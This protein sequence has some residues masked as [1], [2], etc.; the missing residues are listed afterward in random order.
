MRHLARIHACCAQ[1]VM[2]LTAAHA[3]YE[4]FIMC[5]SNKPFADDVKLMQFM[6]V[7][8]FWAGC[9]QLKQ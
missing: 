4:L 3:A 1:P 7:H 5:L 8:N 6:T 2:L 9:I